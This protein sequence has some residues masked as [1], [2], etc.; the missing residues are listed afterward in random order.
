LLAGGAAQPAREP[1]FG[2]RT[3][4]FMLDLR[5]TKALGFLLVACLCLVVLGYTKKLWAHE[6]ARPMDC[7]S[8]SAATRP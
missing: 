6:P 3:E 4:A 8:A 7:C 2:T 1:H 5:G